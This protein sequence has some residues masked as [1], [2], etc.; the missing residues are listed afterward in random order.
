M[1]VSP[2]VIYIREYS[3]SMYQKKCEIR[4]FVKNKTDEAVIR[5]YHRN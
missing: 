3:I 1:K 2:L 4:F 5:F